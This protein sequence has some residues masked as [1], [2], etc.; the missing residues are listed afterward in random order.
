MIPIS[1]PVDQNV[2]AWLSGHD[3]LVQRYRRLFAFIEWVMGVLSSLSPAWPPPSSRSGLSQSLSG[4]VG[5]G[6]SLRHPPACLS[7]GSSSLG[8]GI[9][10]SS[11]YGCQCFFRF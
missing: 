1:L 4:Q 9:G 11:R 7:A 2:L 8:A 5:Q 10:I 6:Q 3:S